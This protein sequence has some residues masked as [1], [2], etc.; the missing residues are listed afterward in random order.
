M[1][2]ST[3]TVAVVIL[4]WNGGEEIIDCIAS[5]AES[6]Y[7]VV[8][9]I[10]VDN[11]SVDGSS[12]KIRLL[13]PQTIFIRNQNNLGFAKGS[14]QGMEWALNQGIRYVLLLN[15]D[16]RVDTGAIQELLTTVKNEGD[17]VAACPR[18]YLGNENKQLWFAYGTVKM[19]A[20]LFQNP[21]FNQPDSA[22]WSIARDVEFASG[23]C[24]LI[25]SQ[26]LQ[27][28]G[29]LDETFFAYCED[30]DFSLRMRK[31]GFRIRYV[32]TSHVWHG[33]NKPTDRTRSATYRY[34]ATRNNLWVVRKHGS[35]FEILTCIVVLPFRSL[36]RIVSML[37]R[38][39]WPSV[40]AE[41]RGV[42]AGLFFPL[43]ATQFLGTV[44]SSK[45]ADPWEADNGRR[46]NRTAI[47]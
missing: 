10:V 6:S 42:I 15:G 22:E 43:P 28:I 32:P 3:Q 26:V 45:C 34:L 21:A 20:G 23:C 30:I 17:S 9:V 25:P 5:V 4:N 24:V 18:I 41:A 12:D 33:S 44:E 13:F 1:S 7:P 37:S 36:F 29:L 14:N 39:N 11:G 35:R 46:S 27:S 47:F 16:A 38:A 31:A 19:W 8:Q 40:V 2:E